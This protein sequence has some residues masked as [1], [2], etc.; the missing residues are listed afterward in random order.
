MK[1]VKLDTGIQ[2]YKI[3]G[4]GILRFNPSDPNLYARF[5]EA[6]DQFQAIEDEMVAKARAMEHDDGAGFLRLMAQGD[7][8]MKAL[9]AQIFGRE[10]DFDEILGGVNLLAVASNGRRVA[11]NL[12]DALLDILERG[13]ER[14]AQAE[15]QEAAEQAQARRAA[16]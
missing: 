7:G 4:G 15:A 13:V 8:Q 16:G 14:C 1:N 3:T 12:F 2:S 9:L 5:V 11:A 6:L 10:N